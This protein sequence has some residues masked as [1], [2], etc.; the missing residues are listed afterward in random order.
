MW[1][2]RPVRKLYAR[3]DFIPPLSDYEFGYSWQLERYTVKKGSLGTGKPRT[4][5]YNVVSKESCTSHRPKHWS[6]LP[7]PNHSCSNASWRFP[8]NIEWFMEVQALPASSDLAPPPPPPLSRLYA[9]PATH[10]K[11]EKERRLADGRGE[12][13]R[14]RCQIIQYDRIKHGPLQLFNTLWRLLYFFSSAGISCITVV[15][16]FWSVLTRNPDLWQQPGPSAAEA[17]LLERQNY[18]DPSFG[19]WWPGNTVSK[20]NY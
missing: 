7:T 3:V 8:E 10:R 9:L 17:A 12:E 14:G 1:S 20:C 13:G 4:F 11:T 5:I 6:Q 2:G 19:S 18:W 15:F 16:D